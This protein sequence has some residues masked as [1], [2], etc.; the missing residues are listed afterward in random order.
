M[1]LWIALLAILALDVAI[2]WIHPIH[3]RLDH[4][5]VNP[6]PVKWFQLPDEVKQ[7]KPIDVVVLGSSRTLNG[8]NAPEFDKATGGK[9]H[10]YNLGMPQAGYDIALLQLQALE[11]AGIRPKLA[12]IEV[13]DFLLES[14]HISD[15]LYYHDVTAFQPIRRFDILME[16][17]YSG[18][19]RR[20]LA[21]SFASSLH[22]YH[23]VLSPTTLIRI[24][25]NRMPHQEGRYPLQQGWEPYEPKEYVE[26]NELWLT[27]SKM[28]KPDFTFLK[29][30]VDYCRRHRIRPVFYTLPDGPAYTALLQKSEGAQLQ[31]KWIRRF[32]QLNHIDWIESGQAMTWNHSYKKIF[33]DGRHL[34]RLGSKV[35]T[36]L[37]ARQALALPTNP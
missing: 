6:W 2:I 30:L 8:F 13:A 24:A 20:E 7:Q 5:A 3:Q 29:R 35:F 19:Q 16:S 37:V 28:R 1:P 14:G 22:R 9:H 31:Q 25:L 12:L 18:D 11:S 10:S 32:A 15:G 21:L 17:F 34:N 23:K 33:A 27:D 36:G 4:M 26:F